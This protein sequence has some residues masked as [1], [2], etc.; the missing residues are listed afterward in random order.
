MLGIAGPPPA[1]G[2][3]ALLTP[4][5][6]WH[7][8]NPSR[9]PPASSHSHFHQIHQ[10]SEHQN[11][12][13]AGWDQLAAVP[14]GGGLAPAHVHQ[15]HGGD[16]QA[17][18]PPGPGLAL[19]P[20]AEPLGAG[21]V[22]RL[23]GHGRFCPG[24]RARTGQGC[25]LP[26]LLPSG[27]GCPPACPSVPRISLSPHVPASVFAGPPPPHTRCVG[28]RA[29]LPHVRLPAQREGAAPALARSPLPMPAPAC[30]PGG[31]GEILLLWETWGHPHQ[32]C[33]K[34][35]AGFPLCQHWSCC[36]PSW[37]WEQPGPPEQAGSGPGC[38]PSRAL[39]MLL[40][41]TTW[42]AV[43]L[44]FSLVLR[45]GPCLSSAKQRPPVSECP[46]LCLSFPRP[47]E[48]W[49]YSVP[50]PRRQMLCECSAPA[51]ACPN[52][53]SPLWGRW[54]SFE[55]PQ[56]LLG[57]LMQG[58][59]GGR[60]PHSS[61][62]QRVPHRWVGGHWG[63]PVVWLPPLSAGAGGGCSRRGQGRA[64]RVPRAP[65]WDWEPR[66]TP[67]PA[68]SREQWGQERGTT[69]GLGGHRRLLYI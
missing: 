42:L 30:T 32:C 38:C 10:D 53:P 31:E 26:T 60:L 20:P 22:S 57:G 45:A 36:C 66:H 37:G 52:L 27:D 63:L 64:G 35:G 18:P 58:R 19:M 23:A 4:T 9:P 67:H 21:S 16:R 3:P 33:E 15:H 48:W 24:S 28:G 1:A 6:V 49:M 69:P 44:C 54:G 55:P 25:F 12:D 5:E 65:P 46:S 2:S 56:P 68:G 13:E 8:S 61:L 50:P 34:R 29:R 62:Q 51:C 41:T 43:F 40:G 17:A 7:H 47:G 59:G 39:P 11:D 14:A